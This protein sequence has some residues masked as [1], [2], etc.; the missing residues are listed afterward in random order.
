ML[1]GIDPFSNILPPYYHMLNVNTGYQMSTYNVANA[2]CQM[3]HIV[4]VKYGMSGVKYQISKF[5]MFDKQTTPEST[6]TM[7]RKDW[8]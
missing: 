7:S 8:S 3:P 4:Q 6:L 5:Q 1:F 2:D